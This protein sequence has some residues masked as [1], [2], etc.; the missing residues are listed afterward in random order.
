MSEEVDV[1]DAIYV[2]VDE[3]TGAE[4]KLDENVCYGI[5][6]TRA[7]S[8]LN[9]NE[10]V[11]ASKFRSCNKMIFAFALVMLICAV[12]VCTAVAAFVEISQFNSEL[13]SIRKSISLSNQENSSIQMIEMRF[14]QDLSAIKNQTMHGNTRSTGSHK[15][16]YSDD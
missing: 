4:L 5:R 13:A 3:I 2:Q 10:R 8:N 11:T 1:D 14:S 12:A 6:K 9:E 16:F 7:E 15:Q